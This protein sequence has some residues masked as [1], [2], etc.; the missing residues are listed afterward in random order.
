MVAVNTH[1]TTKAHIF[2]TKTREYLYK[3]RQCFFFKRFYLSNTINAR[4]A[5]L[6]DREVH[7]QLP[8]RN[9]LTIFFLLYFCVLTCLYLICRQLATEINL[10]CSEESLHNSEKMQSL[11]SATHSFYTFVEADFERPLGNFERPFRF[12]KTLKKKH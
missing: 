9:S 7:S 3:R 11:N 8:G 6:D 10:L 5:P 1:S 4:F 2:F 12:L